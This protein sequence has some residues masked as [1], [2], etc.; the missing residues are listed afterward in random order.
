MSEKKEL[1][2]KYKT[3]NGLHLFLKDCIDGCRSQ[4]E[5][6]NKKYEEKSQALLFNCFLYSFCQNQ[7]AIILDHLAAIL[8]NQ[9]LK[10][11]NSRHKSHF[12]PFKVIANGMKH[13]NNMIK[14][15]IDKSKTGNIQ[16]YNFFGTKIT[17]GD[18]RVE[19]ISKEP[20]KKTEMIFVKADKIISRALL[21]LQERIRKINLNI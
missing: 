10:D 2:I 11:L 12:K 15:L 3:S 9:E 21:E 13:L 5:L 19:C 1:E 17:F 14:G 8:H 7:I 18:T 6:I 16:F 4:W 20:L